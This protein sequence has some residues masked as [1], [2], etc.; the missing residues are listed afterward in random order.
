MTIVTRFAPS[1]T[2]LL[3]IGGARTALFNYIFAKSK[4]GIFKI[5]IEDTDKS[6]YIEKSVGSIL[7]DLKWLGIETKEKIIYQSDNKKKHNNVI[8]RMI[9]DGLAYR[10]YHSEE[11]LNE[12]RKKNKKFKSEWRDKKI[13]KSDTENFCVRI[14][15][16][17]NGVS[18]INDQIQ[19]TVELKNNEIDDFIIKR[20]DGTPT[21]LISSALDDYEMSITH[22]I[23]GDDHLTNS[24]RQLEIFKYLNYKPIFSHMSL[25]HNQNNQKLSKRDNIISINDYKK[26]GFLKESLINYMLRM[27]WS[28]GNNEIITLNEAIEHFTLNKVGKSPSMIDEK[29]LL[30]LNNYFINN[31]EEKDLFERIKIIDGKNS[32]L[33]SKLKQKKFQLMKI[34]KPRSSTTIEIQDKI[35]NIFSNK[36]NFN[37]EEEN[38]LEIFYKNKSFIIDE[39]TSIKEWNEYIIDQKLKDILN[40]LEIKFKELGQPLRLLLTN[41]LNGP[42][43]AKIME[44]IGKELSLKKLNHS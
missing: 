14:K 18:T 21:F 4:K 37:N 8:E 1:P 35:C 30:F 7:N 20:S 39:F 28:Y 41:S 22:I 19:G 2:G 25:I 5:R 13:P 10:C 23:R 17:E 40:K 16:P 34:F 24:F 36:K 26:K 31:I 29:K 44:I 12:K 11:E 43:V 27:G 38:V 9:E 33:D 6:R 3:H 32:D 42:S 15:S